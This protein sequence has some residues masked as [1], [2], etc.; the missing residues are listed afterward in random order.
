MHLALW[1]ILGIL[2]VLLYVNIGYYTYRFLIKIE[3][4][5]GDE[6]F[7]G[8]TWPLFWLIM[9]PIW[10]IMVPIACACYG[11]SLGFKKVLVIRFWDFLLFY[12]LPDYYK[13]WRERRRAKKAAV[14]LEAHQMDL[15]QEELNRYQELRCLIPEKER[16]LVALKQEQDALE[17]QRAGNYRELPHIPSEAERRKERSERILFES[18][19]EDGAK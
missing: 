2:G 17:A 11:I 18:A 15:L 8:A 5:C 4:I 6:T 3:P 7:I 10:L 14:L 16:E 9:V 13:A 12:K 19:D 1:I